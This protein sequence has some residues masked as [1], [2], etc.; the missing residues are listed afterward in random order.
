MPST[1]ARSGSRTSPTTTCTRSRRAAN[2]SMITREEA[3]RYADFVLDRAR[4]RLVAVREDHLRR[5]SLPGQHDLRGRLRRQRDRSSSTATISMRRRACPRMAAT[6]PGCAGTIRACRGRAPSCGWPTSLDDGTLVDGRLIAGGIGGIDLPARVV[7]RRPAALRV[8]PQRLVE[9]VPLR[10]RRRAPAVPARSGVR[11]AALD[12]RRLAVRL[13]LGRRDH[14]HLYRGR[15]QP[16]GAPVDARL[17]A[18]RRSPRPTRK[19]ANCACRPTAWRVLAGSPTIAL[20]LA[21]IDPDTGKRSVLVQSSA[22]LPDVGYLSVPRSIRYRSANGRTAYAFHY[23]P[24]NADFEAAA[25]RTA[26][27]DRDRPRRPDRHGDQHAEAG[28]PVLDQPRLRRA[29]R[30]LRRQHRLRPRLPRPAQGPV[31]RH[32]RR[33]LRGRRAP[34]GRDRAWS[35]RERLLIRGSSAGGLTTLCALTFHDVFKAGASYYGVSDLAGLDADSHKFE[36]HYNDYLIAPQ[37]AGSRPVPRTLADPP[38]RY[39]ET[40]DDLLPGAGRQGGAAAAVGSD[41]RRA[42]RSAACRSPT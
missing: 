20:E 25:G 38:H 8:G 30:E 27:A 18:A 22:D 26:A 32:R 35:I 5:R 1:A 15:R 19:S 6:W 14:L 21:L 42:A 4:N 28:D 40:P 24:A 31:G 13:P 12:L 41:G 39:A 33:G 9:P 7:A 23:A 11:R 17:H 10:G 36:S 37:A 2:R 29:R 16:P 3:V 34:P